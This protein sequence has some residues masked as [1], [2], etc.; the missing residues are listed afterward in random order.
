V[1]GY[2]ESMKDL[3]Y[4]HRLLL[5]ALLRPLRTRWRLRTLGLYHPAYYPR[6]VR[7]LAIEVTQ[8]VVRVAPDMPTGAWGFIAVPDG[9][10]SPARKLRLA[11]HQITVA[12]L[13]SWWQTPPRNVDPEAVSASH[14]FH[15]ALEW[16]ASGLNDE[17]AR[18]VS[19]A[20]DGWLAHHADPHAGI[21]WQPYNV[22]ERI[23]NLIA[24]LPALQRRG[25]ISAES[26]RTIYAALIVHARYLAANLEYPAGGQI[27]NHILNNARALYQAGALLGLS[28]VK[29]LGKVL[30]ELHLPTMIAPSGY[31]GEASSHYHLLL[32]RSVL[33]CVVVAYYVGDETF[34]AV[35]GSVG[36][37]ML[38]AATQLVPPQLASLDDGPRIG[39][40][41]PDT[42]FNWFLPDASCAWRKIW[43]TAPESQSVNCAI[44]SIDDGWL[45]VDAGAWMLRAFT[46]PE[47]DLY[48]AGHGHPDF[49]SFWLAWRGHALVVD[50][51]RLTYMEPESYP[52]GVEAESHSVL[53][54]DDSSLL[55]C[56]RGWR[57]V[58]A[59]AAMRRTSCTLLA[60]G[61]GVRWKIIAR[62]GVCW[63]RTLEIFDERVIVTDRIRGAVRCSK[64]SGSLLLGPN[65]V[66]DSVRTGEW[67]FCSGGKIRAESSSSNEWS[68]VSVPFYPEYGVSAYAPCLTW[69][70][71]ANA[72]I[73]V[74]F[75]LTPQAM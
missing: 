35:L 58:L 27:N 52:S 73:E 29:R 36:E 18:L 24:V 42:P 19:G 45:A 28:A 43:H 15:W 16:L 32:T 59:G 55:P 13:A 40:L 60:G 41:S 22:S 9:P 2:C 8:E 51:G 49:G 48:P 63:Q 5:I 34:A 67:V 4:W 72:D 21:A 70:C 14:R 66:I 23:C 71:A 39:D 44:S 3:R 57:G 56:G 1:P 75:T 69:Q 46:H 53:L 74:K 7:E 33:E 31:L 20:I 25:A 38:A 64:V 47:R 26:R 61:H 10:Q 68:L 65:V 62:D 37:R 30:F 11:G 6:S 54:L 12:D 17:G 50:M